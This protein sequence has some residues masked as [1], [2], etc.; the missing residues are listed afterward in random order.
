MKALIALLTLTACASMAHAGPFLVANYGNTYVRD[1]QDLV[2]RD[3]TARY[4]PNAWEIFVYSDAE[5]MPR[6]THAVCK[7]VVGVV[8]KD[9]HQFP[10]RQFVTTRTA[11]VKPGKWNDDVALNFETECVRSA[12]NNMMNADPANV[13]RPHSAAAPE[14]ISRR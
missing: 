2:T 12:I 7:A 8:P 3:F 9:S 13:Y 14:P 4:T 10:A 11:T 1:W 6:S 5:I